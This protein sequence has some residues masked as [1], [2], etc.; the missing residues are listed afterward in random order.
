MAMQSILVQPLLMMEMQVGAAQA[1]GAGILRPPL[2]RVTC[3]GHLPRVVALQPLPPGSPGYPPM[4]IMKLVS[5]SL[6]LMP[7]VAGFPIPSTVSIPTI[8]A[9]K[10]ATWSTLMKHTL[11]PSRDRSAGKVPVRSGLA[12]ERTTSKLHSPVE[13]SLVTPRARMAPRSLLTV[14]SLYLSQSRRLQ[15]QPQPRHQRQHHHQRQS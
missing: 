5:L 6:I 14:R 2:S 7:V 4:A 9:H 13:L 12:S 8:L 10:S 15:P 3:T 1:T 11:A